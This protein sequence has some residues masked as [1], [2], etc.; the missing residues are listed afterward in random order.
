MIAN[1][2]NG[3][4]RRAGGLNSLENEIGNPDALLFGLQKFFQEELNKGLNGFLKICQDLFISF[5]VLVLILTI[6]LWLI[7]IAISLIKFEKSLDRIARFLNFLWR[8]I[9]FRLHILGIW[10]W[11]HAPR[12]YQ[13]RVIEPIQ[14]PNIGPNEELDVEFF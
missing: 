12:A 14:L 9:R 4:R 8:D 3:V 5:T 11:R 6:V 2:E 1:F 10:D 7:G 13:P